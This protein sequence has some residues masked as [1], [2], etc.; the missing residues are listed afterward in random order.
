MWSCTTLGPKR[1][2]IVWTRRCLSTKPSSASA[3][4]TLRGH[5]T[6]CSKSYVRLESQS[7]QMGCAFDFAL[8]NFHQG[9]SRLRTVGRC[10]HVPSYR[11]I[12]NRSSGDPCNTA[13]RWL[14]G[15]NVE[16]GQDATF[17]IHSSSNRL[18]LDPSLFFQF[19]SRSMISCRVRAEPVTSSID[20]VAS[21]R[22]SRCSRIRTRLPPLPVRT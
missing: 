15:E 12:L 9:Q 10:R 14:T 2:S 13:P 17:A 8:Q 5:R 21:F 3:S 22:A 19:V 6:I 1:V 20:T 7:N 16:K 11:T 18:A 4:S